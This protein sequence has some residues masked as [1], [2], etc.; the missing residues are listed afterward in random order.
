MGGNTQVCSC[1]GI[2]KSIQRFHRNG[3]KQGRLRKCI[4]CRKEQRDQKD[5]KYAML[6]PDRIK[7]KASRQYQKN[8]DYYKNYN[9]QWKK[10]NPERMRELWARKYKNP[11]NRLSSNVSRRIRLCLNGNKN[12]KS[13]ETLVGFTLS[14]LKLHLESKFVDGMTWENYGKWHIDHIIPVSF[15]KYD[16]FDDVEFKICWRLKNLQPLWASDNIRKG[17]KIARKVG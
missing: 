7:A 17:N 15:F 3:T 8:K 9:L 14:Q 10:D 1:C 16:S 6:H 5:I 13:W 11:T 4:D 12:G 2:E